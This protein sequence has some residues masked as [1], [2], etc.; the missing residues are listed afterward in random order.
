MKNTH[1]EHP[2]DMILNG[3]QSAKQVINYLLQVGAS[4]YL[5]SI[6]YDGAPAIV[7]GFNPENNQFFVGTKSVFNKVKIKINYSHHDIEVNHGDRPRVAAILHVCLDNLPRVPGVYQGDFIGFGGTDTYKPNTLTYKFKDDVIENIIVA[8]HTSYTGNSMKE[9]NAE[10]DYN[11]GAR[12]VAWTHNNNK[13]K[14]VDTDA[15]FATRSS[16]VD[17]ILG[18]A[19]MVSNLVRYP[20]KKQ[21]ERLRIEV[22]K[23]IREQRKIDCLPGLLGVL[24]NLIVTAKEMCMTNVQTTDEIQCMIGDYECDHEGYVHTNQYGTHKFVYRRQFSYY[25][26]T[27]PKQW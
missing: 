2:E 27:L 24:Y 9:M 25:N 22:N 19:S 13:V 21:S 4:E 16:R 26:F 18:V 15:R 12:F 3:K 11:L 23:C 6:K 1:L 5:A 8:A 7:W 14:F 20:D 17:F 10:F